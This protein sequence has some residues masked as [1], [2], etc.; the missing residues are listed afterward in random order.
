MPTHKSI[1]LR[2]GRGPFTT[3]IRNRYQHLQGANTT[4]LLAED[5]SDDHD[6]VSEDPLVD[7]R[8]ISEGAKSLTESQINHICD[9]VDTALGTATFSP[10]LQI[11]PPPPPAL[12][13]LQATLSSVQ[14]NLSR[15]NVVT[16]HLRADSTPR[17]L[18]FTDEDCQ[19][20]RV[21]DCRP[22]P[23][24]VRVFHRPDLKYMLYSVSDWALDTRSSRSEYLPIWDIWF[25]AHMGDDQNTIPMAGTMIFQF[26]SHGLSICLHGRHNLDK[27]DRVISVPPLCG[28]NHLYRYHIVTPDVP[29][30]IFREFDT[31][32]K[33][34]RCRII[35]QRIV[36][37]RKRQKTVLKRA[38][39][40]I[41][42][43]AKRPFDKG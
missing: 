43:M 29:E 37:E 41:K 10:E 18:S 14:I 19:V 42:R 6:Q 35:V 7:S 39:S 34:G 23:G 40:A 1:S 27:Q 26:S 2:K 30:T 22:E 21:G 8:S 15:L 13:P 24:C 36:E 25:S 17:G 3:P 11:G 4:T 16:L 5:A 9:D 12:V 38:G 28:D 20:R 32:R 31:K 33:R